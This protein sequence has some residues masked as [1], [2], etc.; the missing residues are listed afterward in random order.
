[1]NQL[2]NIITDDHSASTEWQM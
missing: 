2:D 1:M